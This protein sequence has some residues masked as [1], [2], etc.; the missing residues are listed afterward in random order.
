MSINT[1]LHQK[2]IQEKHLPLMFDLSVDYFK[3]RKGKQFFE[4]VHYFVPPTSSKTKKVVLW[5]IE[6]VESWFIDNNKIE[7]NI[8]PEIENLLKRR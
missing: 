1:F 5:S 6:A 8:D 3:Q 2:Y 4:G 7:I